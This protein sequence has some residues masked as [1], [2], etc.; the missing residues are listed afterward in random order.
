[1]SLPTLLLQASALV[2]AVV[3]PGVA[4]TFA[5]GRDWRWP[6]RLGVGTALGLLCVPLA[7]FCAAWLLRTN[8]RPPL[9]I[10][11]AA[12]FNAL[13]ALAWWRQRGGRSAAP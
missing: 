8:V 3:L 2:W 12:C 1:M 6:V 10:G 7:C 13:G 9:V 5:A 11:V 4:L